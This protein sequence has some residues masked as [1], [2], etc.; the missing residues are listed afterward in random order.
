[1]VCHISITRPETVM[2]QIW[3]AFVSV[4]GAGCPSASARKMRYR[5]PDPV[6]WSSLHRRDVL[7]LRRRRRRQRGITISDADSTRPSFPLRPVTRKSVIDLP[8]N[9]ADGHRSVAGPG[10]VTGSTTI[11]SCAPFSRIRSST[12]RTFSKGRASVVVAG[13]VNA[14]S[15]LSPYSPARKS[16]MVAGMSRVGGCGGPT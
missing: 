8:I 15:I 13:M 2:R 5:G 9:R 7:R 16:A 10:I 14:T 6:S 11:F 3:R 12:D 1:M 4:G